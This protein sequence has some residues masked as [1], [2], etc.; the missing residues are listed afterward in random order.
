MYP[1]DV[2]IVVKPESE[3]KVLNSVFL[4]SNWTG[5]TPHPLYLVVTKGGGARAGLIFSSPPLDLSRGKRE[6]GSIQ[7]KI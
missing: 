2:F 1:R 6:K 3:S 7:T 4:I 5:A